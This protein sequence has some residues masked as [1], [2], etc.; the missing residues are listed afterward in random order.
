MTNRTKRARHLFHPLSFILYPFLL[1]FISACQSSPDAWDRIQASGVL[2]VGLDPTF[3]PFENGDTGDLHGIDVDLARA[4]GADLGL[5]IEFIYFGY[6]GLYDALQTDQTDILLSALV[7]DPQKRKL[8]DYSEPYFNAGQFLVVMPENVALSSLDQ[9][10][11]EVLAVEIGSEG[12]VQGIKAQRQTR[13]LEL[14]TLPTP[15]DALWVVL[16]GE[17]AG[18][19]VDQI[20]GRLYIQQFPDLL[21]IPEPVTVEPFAIVTRIEDQQ[22][23][24]ALNQSLEEITT[25]GELDRI[26]SRWLDGE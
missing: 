1:L 8:F 13:D 21:L 20:T 12:H 17:V 4:I 25:S 15:D 10:E 16:Q 11:G 19:L 2:R 18:A 26:I 3:P 7:I 23:L 24:E 6:D 9:F 14:L 22:L 5:E